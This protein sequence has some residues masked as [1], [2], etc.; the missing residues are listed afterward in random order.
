MELTEHML[1]VLGDN[2]GTGS[3]DAIHDGNKNV[4]VLL[5]GLH[6]GHT[7]VIITSLIPNQN[8]TPMSLH[9]DHEH[10]HSLDNHCH[11]HQDDNDNNHN[12]TI[13][14]WVDIC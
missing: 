9:H 8:V 1:S 2:T 10:D 5:W 14:S 11:N 13:N 7:I 4:A 12:H 3:V 6:H